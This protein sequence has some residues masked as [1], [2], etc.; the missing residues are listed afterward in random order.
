MAQG[1]EVGAAYVSLTVSARGIAQDINRELGAPVDKAAKDAGQSI[2]QSI[3]GGARRGAEAA[4]VAFSA[5]GSAAVLSGINRAKDAASG[6]QQAMGGTAA[7]FGDA[8][9]AVDDFAEGAAEAVGL[10]ERAA[11]ELTSQLG[12]SLKGYGFAVDEAAAKSIELT[13]VGADLAATFGG[14]TA[15]AVA[16]LSSALRGEFDPLERYG[17]ALRQSAIDAEAVSLGL[18]GAGEEVDAMSRAQ[19]ALSLITEQSADSQGQFAREAGSA[20]GQAQISGAKIE[21]SAANLGEALLP[22]YAQLSETIGTVADVFAALPGPVQ[23]GILALVGVAAVAGPLTNVVGLYR[24]FTPAVAANTVA[25]TANATATNSAAAVQTL[26]AGTTARATLA[27]RAFSGALAVGATAFAG[28]AI[29]AGIVNESRRR[30]SETGSEFADQINSELGAVTTYAERAAILNQ[31]IGEYNQMVDDS[32]SGGISDIFSND[33]LKQYTEEIGPALEAQ[34]ALNEVIAAYAEETGDA[35]EATRLLSGSAEQ[36]ALLLAQRYTPEQAA[37]ELAVAARAREERNAAGTT[38][39]LAAETE[40]AADALE[41]LNGELDDAVSSLR[42]YYGIQSS[43]SEAQIA[44][45]DSLQEIA[46]LAPQV[47]DGTLT[48]QERVDEFATAILRGRDNILDYAEALIETGTPLEDVV[49]QVQAMTADLL[50]QADQAG[51]TEDEVT[52]LAGSYGLLPEQITTAINTNLGQV[53]AEIDEVNEALARI[54]SASTDRNQGLADYFANGG[55]DFTGS[56]ASGGPVSPGSWLVGEEGPEIIQVG[57]AGY[58]YNASDTAAML[59]P[60]A[61]GGITL[62]ANGHYFSPGDLLERARE[63]LGWAMSTRGD[64]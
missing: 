50:D 45:R 34:V 16:A 9:A 38:E 43:G 31:R 42:D 29:G 7:V 32:N 59:S 62:N 54:A 14:T 12:A 8:S 44:F 3:G 15:D 10:S 60:P 49:T 56:R 30:A 47:A 24:A 52:F 35:D 57:S 51:L 58:V 64:A 48:G 41:R 20:A 39:E 27:T 5:L 19:A 61:G 6:L 22:I 28:Y 36:A 63:E 21:D 37:A 18:V 17:V 2:E 1:V 26:Y 33:D 23:T 55:F 46:D 25:I 13:N 53:V 40:T 4:K 11:R